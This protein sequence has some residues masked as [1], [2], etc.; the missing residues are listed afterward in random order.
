MQ[1]GVTLAD[2]AEAV[3]LD[4][5]T[6][7]DVRGEGYDLVDAI[8][9]DVM[10]AFPRRAFDRHF[11]AAIE[12]EVAIRTDCQSA[13]LLRVSG[14]AAQQATSPWASGSSDRGLKAG[15]GASLRWFRPG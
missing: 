9:D 7:L 5:S 1:P 2:G 12:R 6:S 13:R 4:R 8:R 11:L 10:R 3:L 14:L 15:P